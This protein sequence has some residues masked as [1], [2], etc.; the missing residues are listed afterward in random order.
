MAPQIDNTWL[1]CHAI[2]K[3]QENQTIRTTQTVYV[4]NTQ[5]LIHINKKEWSKVK[6]IVYPKMKNFPPLTSIVFFHGQL[7]GSEKNV[8]GRRNNFIQVWNNLISN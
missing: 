3:E 8:F 1:A 5:H 7:F 4:L 6:G 2:A